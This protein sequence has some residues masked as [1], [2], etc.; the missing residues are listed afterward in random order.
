MAEVE[1]I[2]CPLCGEWDKFLDVRVPMK[3]EHIAG[4]GVLYA[5]MAVSQWKVCGTCGFVHQNPR[6]SI[7]T[8]NKFYLDGHYHTKVDVAPDVLLASHGPSYADEIDY[9]IQHSG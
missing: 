4:Y 3:D 1:N 7:A 9:A 6:P 8:L 2:A 5:G